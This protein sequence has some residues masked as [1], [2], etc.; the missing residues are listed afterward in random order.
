M[1]ESVLS[2]RFGDCRRSF[3]MKWWLRW[4]RNGLEGLSRPNPTRFWKD[5]WHGANLHWHECRYFPCLISALLPQ[6][7]KIRFVFQIRG[8]IHLFL[9]CYP[10][11][12]EP[13]L[14]QFPRSIYYSLPVFGLQLTTY[15]LPDLLVFCGFF[16]LLSATVASIASHSVTSSAKRWCLAISKIKVTGVPLISS[17]I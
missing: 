4:I 7:F 3:Q 14:Q 6:L 9:C 12:E 8:E 2:Q 1:K 10:Y 15:P 13:C 11:E 16:H 17:H 5:F